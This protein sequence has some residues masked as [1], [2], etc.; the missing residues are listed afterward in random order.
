[1]ILA[2]LSYRLF[3]PPGDQP[4][5]GK[6]EYTVIT[7]S[8]SQTSDA[9][10][11]NEF[12][13]LAVSNIESSKN[14]SDKSNPSA[15]SETAQPGDS[16]AS[17]TAESDQTTPATPGS[18]IGDKG[19]Q[20]IGAVAKQFLEGKAPADLSKPTDVPK[21]PEAT[22]QANPQ[23]LLS[24]QGLVAK[25]SEHLAAPDAQRA[26]I[27]AV[28]AITEQST[29]KQTQ[30]IT[31]P[32]KPA[33]ATSNQTK[34]APQGDVAA[35]SPLVSGAAA[36][37]LVAAFNREST[38]KEQGKT[39]SVADAT[40]ATSTAPETKP[41]EAAEQPKSTNL[42]GDSARAAET[43]SASRA[44]S[45]EA[46]GAYK[47][48]FSSHAP[49]DLKSATGRL[50]QSLDGKGNV[51]KITDAKAPLAGVRNPVAGLLPNG[52]LKGISSKLSTIDGFVG[53]SDK[54]ARGARRSE[55]S[56]TKTGNRIDGKF[57]SKLDGKQDGK[58]GAKP[59]DKAGEKGA[60]GSP[61]SGK[62]TLLN[63]LTDKISERINKSG[64][65]PWVS[66]ADKKP[67]DKAG[68]QLTDK[69]TKLGD[70]TGLPISD[71]NTDRTQIRNS[72]N[73]QVRSGDKAT[74]QPGD[75]SAKSTD[76]TNA[77]LGDKG[78]PFDKPNS[79]VSDKIAPKGA[80]RFVD[81]SRASRA[82]Q[83][84]SSR[85]MG[86]P[87]LNNIAE[88]IMRLRPEP[89]TDVADSRQTQ[90]SAA[91]GT[92]LSFVLKD[93]EIKS[94]SA[95]KRQDNVGSKGD[96]QSSKSGAR[97]EAK[98]S[99][100]D[101]FGAK[102]EAKSTSDSKPGAKVE[103]KIGSDI[104]SETKSETK[105][106]TK[107]DAKQE[108]KPESKPD[109]RSVAIVKPDSSA[110]PPAA[111]SERVVKAEWGKVPDLSPHFDTGRLIPLLL[112]TGLKGIKVAS[113]VENTTIIKDDGAPTARVARPEIRLHLPDGTY[114]GQKVV[115][116]HR[117]PR[118]E[119]SKAQ[120]A[121]TVPLKVWSDKSN[122]AKPQS[123]P[124]TSSLEP[125][126]HIKPI[127]DVDDGQLLAEP[128]DTT[129]TKRKRYVN[130]A[131]DALEETLSEEEEERQATISSTSSDSQ[132]TTA[133]SS[134]ADLLLGASRQSKYLYT[135][136]P[137]DTAESVAISQL[138]DQNLAPLIVRKNTRYVLPA[139][140]VGV[141]P[142]REGAQITLP[143]PAEIAA[144]RKAAQ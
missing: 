24:N 1:M 18:T 7:E 110:R 33:E 80:D 51:D 100:D 97:P 59:G 45:S 34:S 122:D 19:F 62:N 144:Y 46:R 137:G 142:L 26:G 23:A 53:K 130:P 12:D 132:S 11:S 105:P 35:S 143:N 118:F 101:R 96:A 139:P 87:I 3:S 69:S 108:T 9:N 25:A 91:T 103:G 57:D 85:M 117:V 86:V 113:Q 72:D 106:G 71:K 67:G 8:T 127:T 107:P 81:G 10:S 13:Y 77:P 52:E 79:Q 17:T 15:P 114:G 120:E 70:K 5:G 41:S 30:G 56:D 125:D 89:R 134:T 32:V 66:G 83:T 141:T 112:P 50:P 109:S 135:V 4:G 116:G 31:E 39:A 44:A 55:G 65:K 6:T 104:K 136:K 47:S 28:S 121:A 119:E 20:P 111:G 61:L 94:S 75:K 140:A 49:G 95:G 21:S 14:A 42:V 27:P 82:E 123:V 29:H 73:A 43:N 138:Q 54:D 76:R 48:D 124:S 99:S 131:I 36:S 129:S 63:N 115:P 84:I 74:V 58:F 68:A 2:R 133:A 78:K 38:P 98:T 90:K 126:D 37:P 60:G 102:P 93:I 92:R 22:Q 88:H 128:V 64:E 40:K 16:K